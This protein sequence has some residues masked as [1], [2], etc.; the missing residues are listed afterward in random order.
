[1]KRSKIL[2]WA[3]VVGL[4]LGA[5]ASS[6]APTEEATPTVTERVTEAP[7]ESPTEPAT[8][9]PTEPASEEPTPTPTLTEAPEA[10]PTPQP[11]F[12]AIVGLELVTEGLNAP[13]DLMPA[14]DGSGRLFVVDQ[15]GL[16][17]ILTPEGELLDEPFLDIR[18][19]MIGLRPGY[20][21]R[22]LLGLAFHPDYQQNGVFYVYYSAPLDPGAPQGWNHTSHLSRFTVSEGDENRGDRGSEEVILRVDQPQSNHDGGKIAFGPDGYL[23]VALGDGGGANDVG[24]GHVEDWYEANP[25]GNGQDVTENLLGSLLRIDVDTGDP[26]GV[27]EDN[28]FVGREGLDEIWAYGLRNPYRFSFDAGGDLE[29]FAADAGQNLWEE[30]SIVTE[31]GN[32]G[33]NVKEGSH[34][35]SPATPNQPPETCPDADPEGNPLID[36]I[37]EYRNGGPPEGLGLAV[38]GGFVY[39]GEALPGFEGRYV[40]GDW[41]RNFAAGNGT[42]FVATRPESEGSMWTFEELRIATSDDGRLGEFLLAFGQDAENELYVLTSGTP[43]PAARSG[44]VYKIVA[45]E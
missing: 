26:Y 44:R 4:A 23:Y 43:G 29:L 38:V 35:F 31:G 2:A 45:A 34:C 40:F 11:P 13:V 17:R 14:G 33:W 5:C 3:L 16:I 1:M 22:G 7:T 32:Y 36:P 8:V 19:R 30:V 10:T 9:T 18:D 41:S 28:P 24:A 21:E 20:D 15:A 12:E 25:G 39:R 42:L 37:I 27:P 6:E